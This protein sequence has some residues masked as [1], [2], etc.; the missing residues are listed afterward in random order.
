MLATYLC[1]TVLTSFT[2]EK[3]ERE[4]LKTSLNKS[5]ELAL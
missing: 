1:S 2:L 5:Q 3:T 4:K